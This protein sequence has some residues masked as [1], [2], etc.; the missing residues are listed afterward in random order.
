MD[1]L[2]SRPTTPTSAFGSMEDLES[3]PRKPYSLPLPC[4]LLAI[5]IF[6][7]TVRS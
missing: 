3:L 7:G 6:G 4:E 2:D 5:V 1:Q